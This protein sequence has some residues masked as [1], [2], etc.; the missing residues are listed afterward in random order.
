VRSILVWALTIEVLGLAALPAIRLLFRNRRD[1]ALLSRGLG[2]ALVAYGGWAMS[3][4]PRVPFARSTLLYALV[5]LLLFSWVYARKR[6]QPE[7]RDPLWSPEETRAALLFWIPAG[8]FLL[9]RALQ[10]DIWGAEKYM[11]MGMVNSIARYPDTPPLDPWMSGHTINYY[12]W[13]YLLAAALQKLASVPPLVAYNLAVGTFAGLAFQAAACLGYRLSGGL[14]AAGL[15][16]G[17]ATVL[18]GNLQGAVDA[19]KAPLAREFDTWHATRVIANGDTINEFPFFTFFH[20][21]LHPH[22]LALPYYIAAF[23][24]AHWWIERGV[25]EDPSFG[26]RLIRRV[27]DALPVAFVC[28]TAIAANKWNTPAPLFLLLFA[29]ALRATQGRGLPRLRL[30]LPGAMW[31]VTVWFM[32]L[33]LFFP[34]SASYA[35]INRGL[36]ATTLVSKPGELLLVWGLLFGAIVLALLPRKR[37]ADEAERRHR[38]LGV[39]GALASAVFV[40]LL[41]KAP[42]LALIIP[43]AML[44]AIPG[45]SALR[46]RRRPAS[47]YASF[48]VVFGLSMIAGCELIYFRDDYGGALQ[49][50]NTIFKFYFQ[51][52]PLLAIAAAVFCAEAWKSWTGSRAWARAALAGLAGLSLLYPFNASVSRIRQATTFSLDGFAAFARRRPS[53]AAAAAYLAA[54]APRNAVVLEATGDPYSDY[55]RISAHTGIPTV[56]GW[57]N[58]EGLWRA[59]RPEAAEVAAREAA[60]KALYARGDTAAAAE[61]LQRYRVTHV[62]IG[63]LER[64]AG[65]GATRLAE[66]PFLKPVVRGDTAVYEVLPVFGNGP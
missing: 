53:D 3:L 26:K 57:S 35:L 56:L 37:A 45:L 55:A 11:D 66:A 61:L 16:A 18:A 17:F 48:L 8:F 5:A 7:L 6:L 27:R 63:E 30:L 29:G 4:L 40:A 13:G 25:P 14:H 33:V 49:R 51:A 2:L 31:G 43:M 60:I 59:G 28:G 42:A 34:Y 23:V 65:P 22:L 47:L 54:N 36:A 32:G 58:H 41:F 46:E 39:A 52:W 1:A 9:L 62:V 64:Q 10:P 20:A 12:Y 19:W 15:G 44:A 50:M 38:D 21:D 24:L